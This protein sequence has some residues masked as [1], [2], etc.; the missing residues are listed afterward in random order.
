MAKTVHF[1]LNS[2]PSIE[3]NSINLASNTILAT[4]AMLTELAYSMDKQSLPTSTLYVLATPIGNRADLTVRAIHILQI[5]DVIA[6]ED[7]RVTG[8]LL[9]SLQLHKPL[10][11]C[12]TYREQSNIINIIDRLANGERVV[13]C[14]DAGTPAISDPGAHLV[15]AVHA[16]GYRVL[17]IPGV[18]S[19]STAISASG[20]VG[21]TDSSFVF[22]AFAPSKGKLR[23]QFY[24]TLC[25]QTIPQVWFEAPHRIL[26]ALE[27]LAQLSPNRMLCIARELTKQ[28]ESIVLLPC[29]KA[30]DWLR[31]T[32]T[33]LK[34]EF[35]LILGT[36]VQINASDVY[37]HALVLAQQLSAELPMSKAA[38][39]AAN[40]YKVNRDDIYKDLLTIKGI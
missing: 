6:A 11:V 25:N 5:A 15:A 9:H 12:D 20:L 1:N 37:N 2:P 19:L 35:V 24:H 4:A 16:A 28:F 40:H 36:Q 14:S 22:Y 26:D 34:G 33:H 17:P 3:S 27:R 23:T 7:T 39:L 21:C 32:P 30:V 8:H 13:L 18:S 31:N 10:I 38:S 29:I